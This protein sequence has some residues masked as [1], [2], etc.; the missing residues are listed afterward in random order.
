MEEPSPDS[1]EESKSTESTPP[2]PEPKKES[3]GLHGPSL[4][5]GAG[6]AIVSIIS[7]FLAVNMIDTNPE[8]QFEENTPRPSA[9]G[10][11]LE[12][13]TANAAPHLGS[14]NAPITLIEFGDYQCFFC[15]K[16]FHDTETNIVKNYVETGKVKIIFKDF[17]IIGEDS[18]TAA[19]ATH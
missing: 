4:G 11:P 12:I 13:F 19:H 9:A 2:A 7:A 8:L 16:F 17:T 3:R 14:D 10:S 18:I 15:N 5:I 1:K 6:I